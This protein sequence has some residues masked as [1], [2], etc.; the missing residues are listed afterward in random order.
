MQGSPRRFLI[1]R[2]ARAR[3]PAEWR[4][5]KQKLV[6]SAANGNNS[7]EALEAKAAD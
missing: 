3:D 1:F 5:T 4:L 7:I 6:R 2:R